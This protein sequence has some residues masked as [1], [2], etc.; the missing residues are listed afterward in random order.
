MFKNFK[1]DLNRLRSHRLFQDL[2]SFHRLYSTKPAPLHY[3]DVPLTTTKDEVPL[4]PTLPIFGELGL[5]VF[6][7]VSTPTDFQ[8]IQY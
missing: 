7:G 1:Y 2:I 4:P 3:A 5:Q 8:L 6:T